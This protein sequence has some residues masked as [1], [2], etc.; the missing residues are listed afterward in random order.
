MR[1]QSACVALLAVAAGCFLLLQPDLP[2]ALLGFLQVER[3]SS[4]ASSMAAAWEAL[5]TRPAKRW[6]RVAVG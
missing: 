3:A 2:E 1:R 4:P 6:G 5:I